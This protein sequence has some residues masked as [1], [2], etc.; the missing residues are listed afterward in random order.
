VFEIEYDVI[1]AMNS[2]YY[3]LND[4]K[5]CGWEEQFLLKLINS[6]SILFIDKVS[7]NLLVHFVGKK[8]ELQIEQLDD[9]VFKI[10]KI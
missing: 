6:C 5:F 2:L 3:L 7:C 1:V 10:T 4:D 9:I 8:I